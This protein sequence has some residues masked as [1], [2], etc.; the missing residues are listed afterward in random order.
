[1]IKRYSEF[2]KEDER[3]STSVMQQAKAR[4]LSYVKT[5][6]LFKDEKPDE[7]KAEIARQ[8]KVD[9]SAVQA[10]RL[11]KGDNLSNWAFFI[12][13]DFEPINEEPAYPTPTPDNSMGLDSMETVAKLE[14]TL[15]RISSYTSQT[16]NDLMTQIRKALA[17]FNIIIVDEE[18]QL[19]DIAGEYFFQI[20]QYGTNKKINSVYAEEDE[21]NMYLYVRFFGARGLF[22]VA[23]EILDED[24][25]EDLIGDDEVEDI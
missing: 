23:I 12:K 16:I 17:M 6:P 15:E 7:M 25:L 11:S 4:G 19:P 22:N 1:M 3:P 9:K 13:E 10:I 24:G 14:A 8:K 18:P 5:V 2:L 20:E 21:P